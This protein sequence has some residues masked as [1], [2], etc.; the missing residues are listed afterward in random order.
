[1]GCF[2]KHMIRQMKNSQ[3]CVRDFHDL[4]LKKVLPYLDPTRA[5]CNYNLE[6]IMHPNNFLI[7]NK[8]K[9]DQK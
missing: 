7:S 4:A 8:T 6:L 5:H 1:M 3:N 2:G 9:G